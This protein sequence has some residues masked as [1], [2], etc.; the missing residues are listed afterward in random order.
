MENPAPPGLNNNQDAAANQS[1]EEARRLSIQ[2]C[3]QSLVHACQC[4]N[5]SCSLPSC[6]KMKRVVQHT[7][8]CQRKTNGDCPVCKRL[9]A[10]CCY[11]AKDCQERVCL[12]PFCVNIK[13]KIRVQQLEQRLR[14]ALMR[15]RR[16]HRAKHG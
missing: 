7:K 14:Q 2:R 11:H 1:S 6:Q 13:Q 12:V 4:H 16:H 15:R 10:L 5:E 3:N 8:G 9:I